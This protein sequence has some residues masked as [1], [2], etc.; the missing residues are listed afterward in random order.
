MKNVCVISGFVIA[1]SLLTLAN[2]FFHK[3]QE[4]V[5][6]IDFAVS[7]CNESFQYDTDAWI[8]VNTMK[9]ESTDKDVIRKYDRI[10]ECIGRSKDSIVRAKDA[11]GEVR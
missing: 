5:Q 8:L 6:R 3:H 7:S 9:S 11:I 4:D 2:V 1:F 10:L